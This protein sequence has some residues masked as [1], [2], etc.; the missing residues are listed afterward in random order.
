MARESVRTL[1]ADTPPPRTWR[2]RVPVQLRL[3]DTH[4]DRARYGARLLMS[5][6]DDW[7]T[8][9]LPESMSFV[10]PLVRAVRLARK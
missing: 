5:T 9:R 8:L 10:Y 2:R 7:A 1:V 6:P 4:A 3:K